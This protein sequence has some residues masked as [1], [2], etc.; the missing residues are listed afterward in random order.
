MKNIS[1]SQA[2]KNAEIAR[3]KKKLIEAD[4][5]CCI[6]RTPY[7]LQYAHLLP[8]GGLY[9]EYYL[10]EQ[11]GALMCQRCH[12]LYDNDIYFRQLQMKLFAKIFEFAPREAKAYFRFRD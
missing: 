10:H 9:A 11:N 5:H 8:K 7:A 6:C 12:N 4:N 3:L 2:K 1:D